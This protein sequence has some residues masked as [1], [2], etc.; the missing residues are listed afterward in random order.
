MIDIGFSVSTGTFIAVGLAINAMKLVP[1]ESVLIMTL[2]TLMIWGKKEKIKL[3][4]YPKSLVNKVLLLVL[5]G[6]RWLILGPFKDLLLIWGWFIP[7]VLLS[8]EAETLY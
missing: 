1:L 6:Y 2:C 8:L 4:S 7:L 5:I 3:P